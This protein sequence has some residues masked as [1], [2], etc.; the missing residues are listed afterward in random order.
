M[1]K[2]LQIS[3]A[4]SMLV[5]QSG[6]SQY[7]NHL[8][9]LSGYKVGRMLLLDGKP[10]AEVTFS[11]VGASRMVKSDAGFWSRT[12]PLIEIGFALMP[13]FNASGENMRKN[14]EVTARKFT[15]SFEQEGWRVVS[16]P[17][18]Q[19]QVEEILIESANLGQKVFNFS[20]ATKPGIREGEAL[21]C[22]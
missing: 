12:S 18:L 4:D 2:Q 5:V 10:F 1:K 15:I 22:G 13:E 19:I 3:V 9:N 7:Q 17:K 14:T 6:S 11:K 8:A 20:E 21:G 16:N